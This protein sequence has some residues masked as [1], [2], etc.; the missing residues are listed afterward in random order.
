VRRTLGEVLASALD[1]IPVTPEAVKQE[2]AAQE[3]ERAFD[4]ALNN[5]P[6]PLNQI[7]VKTAEWFYRRG[8]AEERERLADADREQ[9]D[10]EEANDLLE[11]E[12][13]NL[14]AENARLREALEEARAVL[15]KIASGYYRGASFMAQKFFSDQKN[16]AALAEDSK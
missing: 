15:F 6:I 10:V 13:A 14:R 9:A 11:T 2:E 12:C 8:R 4:L 5:C 16:S 1:D 7:D 3:A